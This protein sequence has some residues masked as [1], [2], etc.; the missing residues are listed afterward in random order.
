MSAA[1]PVL[2]HSSAQA[3]CHRRVALLACLCAFPLC[4][5]EVHQV[6]AQQW[7]AKLMA[8]CKALTGDLAFAR[9]VTVLK[10]CVVARQME[11]NSEA[12]AGQ[13]YWGYRTCPHLPDPTWRGAQKSVQLLSTRQPALQP[14]L[15]RGRTGISGAGRPLGRVAQAHTNEAACC[16]AAAATAVHCHGACAAH[17][18]RQ[19]AVNGVTFSDHLEAGCLVSTWCAATPCSCCWSRSP[20]CAVARQSLQLCDLWLLRVSLL[21]SQAGCS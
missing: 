14:L 4:Q 18:R 21:V 8:L 13:R 7:V 16:K 9:R 15:R 10:R 12:A 19:V 2:G 6:K 5:A 1:G 3:A 20:P 17:A 11:K